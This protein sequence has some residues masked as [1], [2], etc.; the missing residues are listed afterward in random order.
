[1]SLTLS[2]RSPCLLA[3]PERSNLWLALRAFRN[4]Q[5]KKFC[6]EKYQKISKKKIFFFPYFSTAEWSAFSNSELLK[7]LHWEFTAEKILLVKIP[8]IFKKFF[9]FFFLIF[10]SW[11]EA[12]SVTPSYWRRIFSLWAFS[13]VPSR[14]ETS[15]DDHRDK[16]RRPQRR[17]QRQARKLC[18]CLWRSPCV[19]RA[20]WLFQSVRTCG[21]LSVRFPCLFLAC[22]TVTSTD[23]HRETTTEGLLMS[24][25]FLLVR[26]RLVGWL[27]SNPVGWFESVGWFRIQLVGFEPA[28]G[29]VVN[30]GVK[31][32]APVRVCV[33]VGAST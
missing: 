22:T 29:L 33:T 3:V 19:L 12:P 32:L 27:V 16:H 11:I 14:T 28:V 31:F 7:A 10:Y 26:T 25:C 2:V 30:P 6:C 18:W 13:N 8:K 4:L 15:T 1:M 21:W 23:D 9:F 20:C 17:A 5:L 24:L